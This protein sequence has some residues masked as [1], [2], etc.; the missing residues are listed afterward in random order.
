MDN[1]EKA[2]DLFLAWFKAE[3]G[4]FREDLLEIQDLRSHDAGRGIIAIEEIPQNTTLFTIPREIII[5]VRTSTLSQKLPH[6]FNPANSS[7]DEDGDDDVDEPLDSWT[8]LI[9]VLMYEYLRGPAS[10]WK[11]YIDILPLTFSTPIFWSGD[12]LKELDGTCLTAEKIGKREADEMLKRRVLPVVMQNE[13]VFYEEQGGDRLGESELLALAH[14][15]GSAVMA[16]AF[17]LEEGQE[18]E[19]EEEEGWVEDREGRTMLGMVPM[20]DLLNADAEFNAHVNHGDKLEVTSLRDNLPIGS[21]VLNY[22]G[23][24]PCSEL[25]RRYGYV[26]PGHHR[27]DVAEMPWR[28][29]RLALGKELD[30]SDDELVKVQEMLQEKEDLEEYFILERDSGEPDAQGRLT[31]EP[32]L[33]DTSP[34]LEEQVKLFLKALKK[35]HSADK[36]KRDEVHHDVVARALRA[37]LREY[38]TTM[39]EDEALLLKDD[40]GKRHRMAVEVRLGEKILLR[41]A[42]GLVQRGDND[43]ERV[44]KKMKMKMEV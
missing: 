34:E 14:R 37:K 25:L 7:S 42:L 4:E 16:Y 33:R 40:L 1:F 41:E 24:L 17:D 27:Y 12:E 38:P 8:S 30:V 43:G 15:M 19:E 18:E 21:E 2:T 39:E 35:S 44:G 32:Q 13:S 6:V 36:R 22:Y 3:G 31:Y 23:P 10:K 11:P 26:T 29:V 9:L 28:L 20:A 5:N